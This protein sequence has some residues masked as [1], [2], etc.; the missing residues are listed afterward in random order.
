MT[1]TVI[2]DFEGNPL[3]SDLTWTKV[4]GTT[5]TRS[6]DNVTQGTYSWKVEHS[7]TLSSGPPP[8]GIAIAFDLR[9][10]VDLS[11]YA[12]ETIYLDYTIT[13]SGTANGMFLELPFFTSGGSLLGG[14]MAYAPSGSGTLFGPIPSNVGKIGLAYRETTPA[15]PDGETID[16]VVNIDNLRVSGGTSIPVIMHHRQ[17]Q[18]MS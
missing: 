12:G 13:E 17:Q 14:L 8:S 4:A 11:A 3:S 1:T 6:T 18:G 5:P 2:E 15:N 7:S 10:D 9:A 16:C